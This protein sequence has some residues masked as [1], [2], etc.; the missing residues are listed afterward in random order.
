M[1]DVSDPAIQEAYLDVLSD[2]TDTNW[3]VFG[4]EGNAKIVLQGA[5]SDGF[6]GLRALLSDDQAQFAYLR[7][8]SG[9]E[10]SK[11]AK[12]CFISWCG[13]NVSALKKAKM[14]VHKASVKE[15]VRNF[16]VEIH[17]TTKEELREGDLM[18]KIKKAGGADYSSNSN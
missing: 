3:A 17:A 5:G 14:S 2:A 7:V 1:A 16:A 6:G 13:E 15:I 11:R 18:A 10:E 4:Y 12:F 9:D 8:T